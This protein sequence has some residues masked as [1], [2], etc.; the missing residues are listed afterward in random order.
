MIVPCFRFLPNLDTCN[1]GCVPLAGCRVA[2]SCSLRCN[3]RADMTNTQT[4]QKRDTHTHITYTRAH[5]GRVKGMP[6]VMHY[7]LC[8]ML[9]RLHRPGR[10]HPLREARCISIDVSHPRIICIRISL[11]SPCIKHA[12]KIQT[13]TN[14]RTHVNTHCLQ[15]A[16]SVFQQMPFTEAE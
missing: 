3:H 9:C 4:K 16:P 5:I 14:T 8:R 2:G 6:S 10:I 1:D 7:A 12:H 13:P 11:R 15:G